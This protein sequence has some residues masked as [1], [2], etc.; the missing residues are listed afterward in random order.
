MTQAG[1]TSTVTLRDYLHVIWLRKWVVIVVVVA[2]TATAFLVSY[3]QTRRYSATSLLVY[4]RPPDISDPLS[5]NSS[6]DVNG[7]TLELQSVVNTLNS[8]SVASKAR[9]LMAK[10]GAGKLD[11]TVAASIQEPDSSSGASVSDTVA[12]G[13]ESTDP[14]LAAKVANA[15][16]QAVIDVRAQTQRDRLTSAQDAVRAQMDRFTTEASRLTTDYLLLAQRLNELQVAEATVTG[17][18]KVV[19]AATTP[20]APS[21]PKPMRAAALGFAVGLFAGIALAF[22]IGQFDTRVRTY[23]D[24]SEILGLPVIGRLPR[25][26]K[27][28]LADGRIVTLTE[29]D[30]PFA[31]SVRMMRGNL[32]WA[33]VASDWKSLLVTSARQGEGKSMITCN[34]A[35]A[36]ALTGKK[37]VVVDADLRAPRVHRYF[38]LG[39]VTGLTTIVAKPAPVQE[40][41]RSFSL[42]GQPKVQTQVRPDARK[43]A[44]DSETGSLLVLTSGPTPPNPGE[45]VASRRLADVIAELVASD[46]DYVLVDAPPLLTVGDAADLARSVDGL[47]FVVDLDRCRRPLLEDSRDALDGLRCRK[48]GAVFVGERADASSYYGYRSASS[49]DAASKGGG[50]RR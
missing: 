16:A 8:S 45:V 22:L 37:V 29:P 49:D 48:I 38:D 30:G 24:A 41:L 1:S 34:L 32:S 44:E 39:N 50:R 12:V 20:I 9:E 17:D 6:T 14:V 46:A 36:L 42:N 13:G 23:R 5:S 35:V 27:T 33:A 3:S 26:P 11:Y 7:L 19:Q 31:E 43:G 21:S 4:E 28:T 2:C 40:A 25:V 15:Y 18:F 10:S 47:L